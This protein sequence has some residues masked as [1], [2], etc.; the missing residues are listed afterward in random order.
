MTTFL[1]ILWNNILSRDASLI[2]EQYE[3][4]SDIDQ[5]TVWEHLNKMATEEGWHPEQVKSAQVAI[6]ALKEKFGL[7]ND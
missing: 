6:D 4:L 5:Q 7:T 2:C 3:T 1:E